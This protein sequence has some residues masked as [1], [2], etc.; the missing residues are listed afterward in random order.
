LVKNLFN[1]RIELMEYLILKKEIKTPLGDMLCLA[2]DKGI[3]FLEFLDKKNYKELDYKEKTIENNMDSKA[4]SFIERLEIQLGEYFSGTRR[5]F[6]LP[7]VMTGT[8]FQK[9]VWEEL[10]KISYG[11][12]IS[13]KDEAYNL[14]NNKAY[15][16]VAN[17][18]GRNHIAILIPCHRVIASDGS[19]GGYSGGLEKKEFLL[20]L[21]KK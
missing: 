8:N 6:S 13:Y 11:K 18:N 16:A 3:M 15:R 4:Y 20:A 21:E 2:S 9:N 19:L 7:L 5:E 14:G 10:L 12:T 1:K 17:A